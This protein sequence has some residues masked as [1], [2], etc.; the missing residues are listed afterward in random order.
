MST[1][2]FDITRVETRLLEK[3]SGFTRIGIS[4]TL[5]GIRAQ[6]DFRTPGAYVLLPRE[7]SGDTPQTRNTTAVSA[8]FSVAIVVARPRE[9]PLTPNM[10]QELFALVAQCRAALDGW[11]GASPGQSATM[12]RFDSGGVE[13]EDNATL[14]WLETYRLTHAIRHL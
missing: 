13:G 4:P 7:E 3:T 1:A 9:Q 8:R 5:E 10:P 11:T 14:T 6:F 2:F 12:I